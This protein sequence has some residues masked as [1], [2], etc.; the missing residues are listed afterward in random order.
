MGSSSKAARAV[1][2]GSHLLSA[3]G[4]RGPP[5]VL[6]DI[7]VLWAHGWSSSFLCAWAGRGSLG[8]AVPPELW[9]NFPVSGLEVGACSSGRCGLSSQV[10]VVEQGQLSCW[11]S[12]E[13]QEPPVRVVVRLWEELGCRMCSPLP[14]AHGDLP[15][16]L[17]PSTQEPCWGDKGCLSVSGCGWT[18]EQPR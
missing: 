9:G 1:P 16:L 10:C 13:S 14:P 15:F 12:P 3:G 2:V 17:G 11:V 8:C 7:A 18:F 5:A 4:C 6:A